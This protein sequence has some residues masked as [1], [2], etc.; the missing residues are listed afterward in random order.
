MVMT[1]LSSRCMPH[2]KE[3]RNGDT[4]LPVERTSVWLSLDQKFVH[5]RFTHLAPAAI[6]RAN[7]SW[8]RLYFTRAESSKLP[9]SCSKTS[10]PMSKVRIIPVT[11]LAKTGVVYEHR[12]ARWDF[13]DPDGYSLAFNGR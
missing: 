12:S 8:T 6:R 1:V 7:T 13:P 4:V 5:S 11:S 3:D 2:L 10:K 9:R